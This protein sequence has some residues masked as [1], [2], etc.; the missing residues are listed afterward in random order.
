M[1]GYLVPNRTPLNLSVK[2][3]SLW[4]SEL[5]FHHVLFLVVSVS[6]AKVLNVTEKKSSYGF[7]KM[8]PFLT[9]LLP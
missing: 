1:C 6:F 5:L 4:L 2:P 3:N 8:R 9:E 7:M